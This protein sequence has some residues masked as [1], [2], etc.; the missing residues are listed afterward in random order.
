M[1]NHDIEKRFSDIEAILRKLVEPK[2][3]MFRQFW[4]WAKPYI[5]PFIFGV[6]VGGLTFGGQWQLPNV[7]P[8]RTTIE[9]QA[10][11]GGAAIPFPNGNL[12]PVPL[13]LPLGDWS[14]EIADSPS[15]SLFEEPSPSNPQADAGQTRST[16]FYRPLFRRTW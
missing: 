7:V 3:S 2:P 1:S 16:R 14:E 9:H 13:T 11:Q 5:V 10:A 6:I 4:D 12:S 8:P 15:M